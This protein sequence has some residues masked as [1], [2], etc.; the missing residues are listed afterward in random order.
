MSG[1]I[2]VKAKRRKRNIFIFFISIIIF[3]LFFYI[4]PFFKLTE[5]RPTDTLLPSSLEIISPEIKLTT[6]E[7]ESKIF[8][9]DQKI[10]FRNNEIQ[11]IKGKIQ[12]LIKE[13]KKLLDLIQDQ[14][15]QEVENINIQLEKIKKDHEKELLKL[16]DKILKIT[17]EKNNLFKSMEKASLDNELSKKEYKIIINKNMQLTSLKDSLK[18][19]IKEQSSKINELN[20]LIQKLKD[21]YHHR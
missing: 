14:G 13:N 3:F 2:G 18:K 21:S 20:L 9:K 5:I 10:I 1:F 11:N 7:L 4:L 12:I 16:N 15:N 8:D 19:E 6:E 17:N